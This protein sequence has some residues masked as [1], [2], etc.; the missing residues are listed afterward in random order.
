MKSKIDT[1]K[2]VILTLTEEEASWL[3]GRM[4]N[5]VGD[6]EKEEVI[7]SEMRTKF[8]EALDTIQPAYAV[9]IAKKRAKKEE[10]SA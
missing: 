8:R 1:Y 7:D 6:Y 5:A 4:Q 2:I 9:D 10:N 3:K